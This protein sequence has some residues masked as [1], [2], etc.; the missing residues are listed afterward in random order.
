[1]GI[2][3]LTTI[4]FVLAAFEVNMPV[5]AATVQR[6]STSR[7]RV[8]VR[9][10]CSYSLAIPKGWVASPD[11]QEPDGCDVAFA[12]GASW[13]LDKVLLGIIIEG[14]DDG[15]TVEQAMSDGTEGEIIQ[16]R[17]PIRTLNG[18]LAQ[19]QYVNDPSP[20]D[21]SWAAIAY[22][23]CNGKIA[24]IILSSTTRQGLSR[25]LATW[26]RLVQSFKF[27]SGASQS[28]LKR[29]FTMTGQDVGQRNIQ[30]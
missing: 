21:P 27:E 17:R 10:D 26:R 16:R 2:V 7:G 25:S 14:R 12:R 20:D 22:V 28:Q 30:Y 1:M 5:G 15:L 9:G 4:L 13:R 8:T 18:Y 19:T 29:R 11:G 24:S 6:V 23:E 3:R